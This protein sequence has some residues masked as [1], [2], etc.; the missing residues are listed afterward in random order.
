M[1][2]SMASFCYEQW[3]RESVSRRLTRVQKTALAKKISALTLKSAI[4]QDRKTDWR[5]SFPE[6]ARYTSTGISG[7]RLCAV[8]SAILNELGGVPTLSGLRF[9]DKTKGRSE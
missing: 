3:Y 4:W 5:A 1:M 8:L 2:S 6:L 7:L 9:P